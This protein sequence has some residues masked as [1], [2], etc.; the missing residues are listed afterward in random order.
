VPARSREVV[1]EGRQRPADARPAALG[2]HG[3]EAQ[4]GGG[5]VERGHP[6][7]AHDASALARGGQ[8]AGG[9]EGA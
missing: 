4:L 7:A 3:Q 9:D 1:R 8:L 5:R 6:H 2:G